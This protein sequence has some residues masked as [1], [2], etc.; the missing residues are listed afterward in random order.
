M[1]EGVS[2]VS[3]GFPSAGGRL[4]KGFGTGSSL[5]FSIGKVG[6]GEEEI[7][8]ALWMWGEVMV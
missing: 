8:R 1:V 2:S 4:V 7:K 6:G 3:L 5:C